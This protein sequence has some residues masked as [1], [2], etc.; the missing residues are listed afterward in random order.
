MKKSFSR[1]GGSVVCD[2]SL[3]ITPSG[4]AFTGVDVTQ[5]TF[6]R[7][8]CVGCFVARLTTN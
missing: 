3:A 2:G 1:Q 6:P 5:D 8:I 4:H 7:S